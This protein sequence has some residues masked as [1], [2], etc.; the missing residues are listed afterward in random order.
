[1]HPGTRAFNSFPENAKLADDYGI[2]MGSS[3][4]EIML[5]NNEAEWKA[6]GTYGPYDFGINRK[7]MD[8][9]W[10]ERV[11][12][13][14]QFENTYTIGLRGIHDTPMEGAKLSLNV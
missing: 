4:C 9:Y 12:A 2:V 5:R 6:V 11:K 1:M 13:N 8:D 3:H 7:Q 14:A 10:E